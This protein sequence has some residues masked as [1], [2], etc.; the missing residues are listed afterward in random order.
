MYS[1]KNINLNTFTILTSRTKSTIGKYFK[2]LDINNINGNVLLTEPLNSNGILTIYPLNPN[3]TDYTTSSILTIYGT[4]SLNFPIDARFDYLRRYIW[5]ADAGN[6]RVLLIDSNDSKFIFEKTDLTLP[7]SL[8]INLNNG[9]CFIKSYEDISTG[10]ITEVDINGATSSYF[11]F[12]SSFT[13]SSLEIVRN[14]TWLYDLPHFH[15]TC[16]DHISNRLWW[17][18]TS[19]VYMIDIL[20]KCVSIY[21]LSTEDFIET[22]TINIDF[23]SGNAFIIAKDSLSDWYVVQMDKYNSKYIGR[24]YIDKS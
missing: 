10:L 5:I 4:S 14:T 13:Y 2:S 9:S 24:A 21:N 20:T 1:L 7:I 11:E 12:P 17:V 3:N 23:N 8:S 22:R 19:I 15:S 6:S 18:D 16:F